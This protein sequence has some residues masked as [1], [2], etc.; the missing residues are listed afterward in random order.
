MLLLS[1][2]I[3]LFVFYCLASVCK[4]V[5]PMLLDRCLSVLSVTLVH[6]GQPVGWM[7]MLLGMEAGFGSGHSVLNGNPTPPKRAQPPNFD[8]LWPNGWV[9][10]DTTRHGGRPRTR[11]SC[12]RWGPSSPSMERGTAAPR[13]HF[14]A[15][16]AL[17]R[18]PISA[19]TEHL[20]YHS[21]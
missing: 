16:F 13:P 1:F 4:T 18:S 2:Y 9:D 10:Q 12:I 14:S 19:A 8:L 11:R 21:S 5:R 20:L 17:A 15:H 7:K 6:C 3:L